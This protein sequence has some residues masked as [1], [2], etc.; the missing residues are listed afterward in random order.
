MIFLG[1]GLD[2]DKL[3]NLNI[4]RF[5]PPEQVE[6]SEEKVKIPPIIKPAS[7]RSFIPEKVEPVVEKSSSERLLPTR[8]ER[9]RLLHSRSSEEHLSSGRLSEERMLPGRREEE[10]LPRRRPEDMNRG[11][12]P[13]DD[14]SLHE[15]YPRR[16]EEE[17]MRLR[18]L[19]NVMF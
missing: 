15:G 14:R 9:E 12:L 4:E 17:Y 10:R 13:A 11:P 2:K 16:T 1:T 7:E 6:S 5:K 18:A 8:E 19:G 3:K